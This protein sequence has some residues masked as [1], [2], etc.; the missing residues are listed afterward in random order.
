ML[1]IYIKINHFASGS[2]YESVKIW[3][4]NRG[5]W[6]KTLIRQKEGII[7]IK[8]NFDDSLVYVFFGYQGY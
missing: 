1:K 8:Q 7:Y 2:K 6:I 5:E 4:L 3:D